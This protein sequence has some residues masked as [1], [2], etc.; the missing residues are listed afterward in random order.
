MSTGKDCCKP[1]KRLG[2]CWTPI[3]EAPLRTFPTGPPF[4]SL[5]QGPR[6]VHKVTPCI[7]PSHPFTIFTTI[8]SFVVDFNPHDPA[9]DAGQQKKMWCSTQKQWRHKWCMETQWL[10]LH[11]TRHCEKRWS[12]LRWHGLISSNSHNFKLAV[13][14]PTCL[15]DPFCV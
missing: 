1:C 13:S 2:T 9:K 15:F 8:G 4:S 12:I 5:F 6:Q 14:Q 11:M 3:T 10:W 7:V